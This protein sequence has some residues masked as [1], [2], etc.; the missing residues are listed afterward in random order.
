MQQINRGENFRVVLPLNH[1]TDLESPK[2][3]RSTARYT[4]HIEKKTLVI[5]I[6]NFDTQANAFSK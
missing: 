6:Y 1:G 3:F 4:M 5:Q 2:S